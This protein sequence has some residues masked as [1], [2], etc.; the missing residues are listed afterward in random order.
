MGFVI[1]KCAT[2]KRKNGKEEIGQSNQES[3]GTFGEEENYKYLGILE[4]DTIKQME[5][6]KK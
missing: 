2:L 6:K 3:I 4:V 1:E 5:M